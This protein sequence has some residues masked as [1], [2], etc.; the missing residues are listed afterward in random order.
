[1]DYFLENASEI[2]RGFV[3]VLSIVVPVGVAYWTWSYGKKHYDMRMFMSLS[4]LAIL[5]SAASVVAAYY[6]YAQRNDP[7]GVGIGLA[8]LCLLVFGIVRNMMQSNFIFGLWYSVVQFLISMLGVLAV[9][10]LLFRRRF[11]WLP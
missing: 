2:T 7:I 6:L 1:M 4:F 11:R 8:G 9:V 5:A 10:Y 3:L